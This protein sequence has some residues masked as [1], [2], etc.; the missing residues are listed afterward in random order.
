[1]VLSALLHLD[2][3]PMRTLAS[4][5][6]ALAAIVST[7]AQKDKILVLNYKF[8]LT[9]GPSKVATGTL[10]P[11]FLLLSFIEFGT[12]VCIL[13]PHLGSSPGL[14]PRNAR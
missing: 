3:G 1:M 5:Q 11:H 4:H 9:D 12:I 2:V 13:P 14:E 10:A 8:E 6:M 7:I